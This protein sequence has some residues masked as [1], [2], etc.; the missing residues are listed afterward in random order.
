M[1]YL[2]Y[3]AFPY[4]STDK[5]I[6]SKGLKYLEFHIALSLKLRNWKWEGID[7]NEHF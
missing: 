1:L 6:D 3:C 7:Y 4:T 2:F 5:I